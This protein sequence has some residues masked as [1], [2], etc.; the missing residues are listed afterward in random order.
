MH[1]MRVGDDVGR[2]LSVSA[3]ITQ[4]EVRVRTPF[5]ELSFDIWGFLATPYWLWH[6][7]QFCSRVAIDLQPAAGKHWVPL[8]QTEA[9]EHVMDQY[10]SGILIR[11][12][13][14]STIVDDSCR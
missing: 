9:D 10:E 3:A 8:L 13:S 2:Q 14:S 12:T 5:C 7:W 1:H 6:L 4:L 11:H